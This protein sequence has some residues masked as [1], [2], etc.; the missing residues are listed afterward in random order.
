MPRFAP[1]DERT[2][3]TALRALTGYQ[4]L[5]LVMVA[6]L[7][8]L[9]TLGGAVRVTDSGL[10]CPDWPLCYG[11]VFPS[12][13]FESDGHVFATHQVYLEWSHRLVASL[14]GV[15]IVA[16]VAGAWLR[17]RDRRWVVIPATAG[18]IAL[19]VQVVMGGLTVTEDLDPGIVAAHLSIAMLI[20]LLLGGAWLATFAPTRGVPRPDTPPP[21]TLARWALIAGVGVFGLMAVGGYVSGREAGISCNFDWP[22]CNGE[23]FPG[24]GPA[25]I[26]AGHRLIAAI[27]GLVV[28]GLWLTAWRVRRAQTGPFLLA[29]VLV[30][31]MGTQAIIGAATQWT[32]FSDW[33]RIV[34]LAAGAMTWL[35][36]VWLAGLL[37]YRA[38]WFPSMSQR[39]ALPPLAPHRLLAKGTRASD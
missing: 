6:G 21:A 36:V 13:P 39:L 11:E 18:L 16:F 10:A 38:H 17:H 26:Q 30:L 27:V 20:V 33:S 31:L 32:T 15:A 37:T 19:G 1:T 4:R 28:V 25:H 29:T 14:I 8:A 7:L 9:M 22:R 23:W 2:R 3:M 12:G 34:H 24:D 35:V 5:G